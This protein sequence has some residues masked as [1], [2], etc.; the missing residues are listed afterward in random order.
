MRTTSIL[1]TVLAV[2]VVVLSGCGSDDEGAGQAGGATPDASTSAPV[3]DR[4]LGV[5]DTGLGEIVVD[6]EGMTVYVFDKDT[7]GSGTSACT[8]GCLQAWPPVVAES[9]NPTADGVSGEVGT[10]TRDDGTLQ[11]T[12]EGYPLYLWQSDVAPGDT[13][14]QGVQGVW[15]VVAPDGSKVTATAAPADPPAY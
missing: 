13:T 3:G 1:G 9:E 7:P 2:G 4:V 5:A 15:W 8:G 12:L 6:G 10:I 14:G 11:V